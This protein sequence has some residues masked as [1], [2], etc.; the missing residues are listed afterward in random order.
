MEPKTIIIGRDGNQPFKITQPCVSNQHAKLTIDGSVWT[1]EDLDSKN[2]TFVINR[3][4]ETTQVSRMCITPDTLICLG[5]DNANGCTFYA[6]LLTDGNYAAAFNHLE[7]IDAEFSV[8]E[9]KAD[10]TPKKIRQLIGVVQML[11]IAVSFLLNDK[12]AG[13]FLRVGTGL[14]AICSFLYD[15]VQKKKKLK[16]MRTRIFKCPNP[17]CSGSLTSN[18]IKNHRCSKCRAQG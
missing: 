18:E 16:D 7:D 12:A 4:G 3:N 13:M 10:N 9:D 5:P 15:P 8:L 17:A 14:S 11:M 2:G 1:L 6:S